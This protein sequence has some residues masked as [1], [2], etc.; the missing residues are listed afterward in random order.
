MIEVIFDVETQKLFEEIEDHDPSKLGISIVSLY[1]REVGDSFKEIKGAMKSFWVEEAGREPRIGGMWPWFEEA[2]RIIGFNSFGFDVP[3]LQPLYENDFSKLNH[4]DLMDE[5]KNVLGHRL[6]L[7]AIA[8]ETLGKTKSGVGTQAVEWWKERSE[9][10]LDL[11]QKYCEMD[12]MVTKDVYDF[13]LENR[14]LKYMD[15][16][17]E[18]REVG[19]DFSY[20]K[21][22][23]E[24]EVQMGLF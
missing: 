14:K 8:K 15:K 23:L 1:R 6:S 12:V 21:K 10:S 24:G 4:F 11:L 22:D 7:D 9:K 3:A 16:W 18:L 20:P 5:V 19:V 17:N 13:G 2:D